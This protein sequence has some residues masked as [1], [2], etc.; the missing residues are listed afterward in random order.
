MN[1]AVIFDLDGTLFNTIFDIADSLNVM[2]SYF[3][4][5]KISVNK[6]KKI[7]G[8]GA[9]S[10]VK[11]ASSKELTEQE[12]LNRLN[13]YNDYYTN[14]GHNKTFLYEGMDKVL[15]VLKENDF[16]LNIISNK[17]QK[18]TEEICNK[19]L[20]NF[21]FSFIIGDGTFEKKPSPKSTLFILDKLNVDKKHAYF[22]GD[23]ETDVLTAKNANLKCI[24]VLYGFRT[25]KELAKTGAFCFAKTPIS[26]LDF[27]DF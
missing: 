2:L 9:K 13:F 1:K 8:N 7:I 26:I 18:T 17:P 14:C 16:S 24:S 15:K 5:K 10:L 6:T 19:Y 22:I 27:I 4:D 11:N 3:N 12:L 20:K 25:K 23:G 21:D